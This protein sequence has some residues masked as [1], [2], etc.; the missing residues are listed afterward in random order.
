M[1]GYNGWREINKYLSFVEERPSSIPLFLVR[2]G[3][4]IWTQHKQTKKER[5]FPQRFTFRVS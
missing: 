2:R 1:F 4:I 3:S 5:F